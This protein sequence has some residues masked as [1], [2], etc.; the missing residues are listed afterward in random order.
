M[1]TLTKTAPTR[2]ALFIACFAHVSFAQSPI[3]QVLT[4]L[5]S[6]T[7]AAYRYQSDATLGYEIRRDQLLNSKT[8]GVTPTLFST[9]RALSDGVLRYGTTAS[10]N[11]S[12]ANSSLS[13]LSGD[14]PVQTASAQF[15]YTIISDT[16]R[17]VGQIDSLILLTQAKANLT[18]E[19]ILF[20]DFKAIINNRVT[21]DHLA[22]ERVIRSNISVRATEFLDR[23]QKMV[24]TGALPRNSLQN[25]QL[26][27]QNN[28]LRNQ[29]IEL[30]QSLLL[31]TVAYQYGIDSALFSAID[32]SKLIA[33]SDLAIGSQINDYNW[34]IDSL[35]NAI[36]LQSARE[37]GSDSWRVS[38]GG[39]ISF[40]DP[41]EPSLYTT[42]AIAQ[43][44]YTF[45]KRALPELTPL[46]KAPR[47]DLPASDDERLSAYEKSS[48]DQE[49]LAFQWIKS[50]LDRI[51]LGQSSGIYEISDNLVTIQ[52]QKLTYLTL[53]TTY[54]NRELLQLR[55]LDQLSE[56]LRGSR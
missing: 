23:L 6:R 22:Q 48:S 28:T 36:Q 3:T 32:V 16:K 29:A 38:A 8:I 15:L 45:H 31:G 12:R 41:T 4:V 35:N 17:R 14:E 53:K 30:E 34:R 13:F 50:A 25:L 9:P 47:C 26:F 20:T 21:H 5:S 56:E 42:S 18:R 24:A 27:I 40:T 39:G 51:N 2:I 11:S 10:Y 1:T 37:Q 52:N 46:K 43:V 44:Q 33:S 54:L 55:S 7:D 19:A 49:Q